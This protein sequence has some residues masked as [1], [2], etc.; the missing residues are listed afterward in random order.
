MHAW[1]HIIE[2]HAWF[3]Q[4]T[5]RCTPGPIY[6]QG[7]AERPA[8]KRGRTQGPCFCS[9]HATL[10]PHMA[11][12]TARLQSV[13]FRK[14][15][16]PCGDTGVV[17]G[18]LGG[19]WPPWAGPGLR[20]FAFCLVSGSALD[21]LRARGPGPGARLLRDALGLGRRGRA[22]QRPQGQDT[23]VQVHNSLTGR[24]E[25]LIVARTDAVSWCV[26]G[27]GRAGRG[28][29]VFRGKSAQKPAGVVPE[30][31]PKHSEFVIEGLGLCF[32]FGFLFFS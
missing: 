29:R 7:W 17:S 24:K 32:L 22:W 5:Q 28:V 10:L 3:Q 2:V 8:L 31:S 9:H 23:G 21:M 13:L 19:A 11:G 14:R 27:Q 15:A 26:R 18:S 6:P 16:E 4:Q 1:V 30:R 25:P 20:S 12:F